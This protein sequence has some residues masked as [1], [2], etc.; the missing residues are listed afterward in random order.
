MLKMAIAMSL[1]QHE[2]EEPSSVKGELLR[3]AKQK[4]CKCD[5]GSTDAA[6]T[7]IHFIKTNEPGE[8]SDMPG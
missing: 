7:E 8:L 3:N 2:E 1:E 4:G 5:K 6:E